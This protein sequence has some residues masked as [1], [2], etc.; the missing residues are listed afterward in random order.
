MSTSASRTRAINGTGIGFLGRGNEKMKDI[1]VYHES[2]SVQLWVDFLDTSVMQY[3]SPEE[4]KA[5][6]KAFKRCAV[7]AARYN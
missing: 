7:E 3:L 2:G 5:F 4:A 1:R 6:A